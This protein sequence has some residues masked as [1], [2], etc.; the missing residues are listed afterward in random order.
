MSQFVSGCL[1][2]AKGLVQSKTFWANAIGAASL[3]F[4]HAAQYFKLIDPESAATAGGQIVAALMFGV[5]TWGRY[6]ATTQ[7]KAVTASGA[8]AAKVV[9]FLALLPFLGACAGTPG[10]ARATLDASVSPSNPTNVVVPMKA[11]NRIVTATL[12]ACGAEPTLERIAIAGQQTGYIPAK[13]ATS[14]AVAEVIARA[15]CNGV[16]DYNTNVIGVAQ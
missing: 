16:T 9:A 4:P 10:T 3:I 2:G 8:S 12:Q 15:I 6:V 7:I 5:S 11:A 13:A 14:I 1:T